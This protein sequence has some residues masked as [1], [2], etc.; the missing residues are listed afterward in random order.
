LVL[1]ANVVGKNKAINIKRAIIVAIAIG[2]ETT[3]NNYPSFH[4]PPRLLKNP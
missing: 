2:Q 1:W 4:L 3:K